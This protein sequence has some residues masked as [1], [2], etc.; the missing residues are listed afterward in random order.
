MLMSDLIM[1]VLP[2]VGDMEKANGITIYRAATS[3][4]SVVFKNLLNRKSDLLATGSLSLQIPAFGY[5]ATLPTDFLSFPTRPYYEE[6]YT[7]WMAGTV[8]SYDDETGEL[9]M[10]ITNASGEDTLDDWV[11]SS[12]GV[13]GVF[14][15]NIGTSSSSV[16]VGTGAKTFTVE[17]GLSIT[18]GD[19]LIISA[20]NSHE[21]WEGVR[22]KME[23]SYLNNDD[24]KDV[25]WWEDYSANTYDTGTPARFQILADTIYIRPK[26]IVDVLVRGVYNQ[27]PSALTLP[28][29]TVPW[30][31]KFDEIFIEGV[32]L[33]L[34]LG[35]SIPEVNPAFLA[36]FEREFSTV[37]NSRAALLPK[38]HRLR[39]SDFM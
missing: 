26:P 20:E 17:T 32:V 8:T 3:V 25:L 18:A 14:A 1:A 38:K 30:N 34:T 2:R 39:H 16:A 9:V 29:Q 22:L 21:G 10:S 12:A 11:V 24:D 5:S 6:L 33:I 36:L 31:G 28:T 37:M 19:Y 7:N 27:A 13:P 23:P 35:L 15:E 4:Q